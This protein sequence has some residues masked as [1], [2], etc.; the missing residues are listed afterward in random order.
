[1]TVHGFV[2]SLDPLYERAACALVPLLSGGGSPVKFIEAL[3]RGLPVVATPRAAA[4]VE[5]E[6]GRQYLKGD[7]AEAFAA[8]VIE[9][10]G[11]AEVGEAGRRLAEAEY[12]IEA[13]ARRLAA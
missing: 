2:D 5:A 1:V 8:A 10:V 7:G 12:S 4:G 9:A 11:A 13:L 6:A 3:A